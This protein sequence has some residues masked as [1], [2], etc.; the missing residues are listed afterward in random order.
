MSKD[1]RHSVETP[2]NQPTSVAQRVAVCLAT[3]FGICRLTPAPG[4]VGTALFGLPVAWGVGQL[5]GIAWQLAATIAVALVGIPLTTAANRALGGGKDHQAIV[6][7]EI[8][9]MPILFL[10]VPMSNWKVAIVG[11]ALFRFFDILKPPPARQLERLPEGVGIMADDVMA[12]VY[13][14]AVLLLLAW[15]DD[16]AALH[17]L[18]AFPAD[19]LR[20][21]G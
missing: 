10:L 20:L 14:A 13:A 5:P 11:F 7:D 4:T 21:A 2:A 12:A 9:A 6:W 18:A 3:G 8:A 19:T 1:R 17:L 16:R 15:L